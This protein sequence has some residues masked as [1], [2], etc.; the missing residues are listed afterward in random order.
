MHIDHWRPFGRW[1]GQDPSR[2]IVQLEEQFAIEQRVFLQSIKDQ[3]ERS[4]I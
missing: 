1:I 3:R 4:S 2:L